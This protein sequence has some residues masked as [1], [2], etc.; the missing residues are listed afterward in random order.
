MSTTTSSRYLIVDEDAAIRHLANDLA[1]R[2]TDST[3]AF[4]CIGRVTSGDGYLTFS[5][6]HVYRDHFSSVLDYICASYPHAKV[7][8]THSFEYEL[9]CSCEQFG[10]GIPFRSGMMIATCTECRRR[11]DGLIRHKKRCSG[12]GL[13]PYEDG[14]PDVLWTPSFDLHPHLARHLRS[15]T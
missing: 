2:R 10:G 4:D 9:E 7:F 15:A 11:G 8:A 3:L 14:Q 6:A 1:Q 13:D 5:A 12:F